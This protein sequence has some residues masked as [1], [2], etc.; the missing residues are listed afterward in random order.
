M[1]YLV[2]IMILRWGC[3]GGGKDIVVSI[4]GERLN[5]I[6][7]DVKSATN[8]KS[9]IKRRLRRFGTGIICEATK[10]GRG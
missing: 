5:T 3:V 9:D 8:A 6:Q 2:P 4:K 7:L 10:E 1:T